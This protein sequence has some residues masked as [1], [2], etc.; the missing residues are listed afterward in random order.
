[1]PKRF[2]DG[3]GMSIGYEGGVI[4]PV[5]VVPQ[6]PDRPVSLRMKI[7]YA[8]CK[9]LCVPAEGKAEIKLPGQANGLDA[10]LAAA[11]RRVPKVASVA[12][13]GILAI[14][15]VRR[16]DASPRPRVIVDVAA[17][18]DSKV[19]LFAEGPTPDWALPLP[20]PVAGAPTGL[21]RFVFELDGL[22]PGATTAGAVLTLTAVSGEDAIEVTTRLD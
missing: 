14:R 8:V 22:P 11:E 3:A 5:R 17:P 6:D 20:A 21:R 19:D 9:N 2:E 18:A 12:G 16:E 7:D 15:N 1:V 10:T 4:F 13:A